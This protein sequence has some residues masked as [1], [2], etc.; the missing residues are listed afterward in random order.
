MKAK[1]TLAVGLV[2]ALAALGGC[3]FVAG[4]GAGAA[5]YH[6]YDA[7]MQTIFDRSL[8]KVSAALVIAL[9]KDMRC[10][11]IAKGPLEIKAK[12][13]DEKDVV[14]KMEYISANMTQVRVR[15]GIIGDKDFSE[16]ILHKT[17]KRL[18][19]EK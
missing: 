10:V 11:V 5:A 2:L 3:L 4:A 19:L 12:T 7:Q 9:E 17:A 16:L 1:F 8:E 15:V 18:G 14:V 13:L 6:F